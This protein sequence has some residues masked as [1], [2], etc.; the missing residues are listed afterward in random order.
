MAN[1]VFFSWQSSCC[2]NN[3]EEI[4]E[5]INEAIR[6]SDCPKYTEIEGRPLKAGASQIAA[7]IYQEIDKC[8]VFI[9]DLSLQKLSKKRRIPN[10]NVLIELGYAIKA[11][12]W[13]SIVI[14]MNGR[15]GK[16]ELLPFDMRY[17]TVNVFLSQ[18]AE[19]KEEA[20]EAIKECIN[21]S[22][23]Y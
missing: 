17:R 18:D 5:M 20:I 12:G 22:D 23:D 19:T 16:P 9:C 7:D 2:S 8:E 14:L 4:A 11:K 3:R 6:R 1:E 15:S 13:E 10:P 21:H